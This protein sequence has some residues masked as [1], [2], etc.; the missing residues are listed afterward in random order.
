MRLQLLHPINSSRSACL[1]FPWQKI[2][3]KIVTPLLI[4]RA[5]I[6]TGR[7]VACALFSLIGSNSEAQDIYLI[8]TRCRKDVKFETLTW[9]FVEPL[10]DISIHLLWLFIICRFYRKIVMLHSTLKK[11]NCNVLMF[12]ILISHNYLFISDKWFNEI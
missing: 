5:V 4:A 9:F 8:G 1:G 3:E 2:F 7:H 10:T 6:K 12:K 11:Y